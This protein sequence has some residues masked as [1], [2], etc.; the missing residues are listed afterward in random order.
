MAHFAKLDSNNKVLQVLEVD[1]KHCGGPSDT[2]DAIGQ[3]FL[4]KAHLESSAIWKRT[5]PDLTFRGHLAGKDGTYDPIKD[6]FVPFKEFP[7][8]ILNETTYEWDPPVPRPDPNANGVPSKW[9]EAGQKWL[10]ETPLGS[11]VWE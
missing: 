1:D 6:I 7:S 3:N 10:E 8:W 11:G 5:T 9:D 4:R 2:G